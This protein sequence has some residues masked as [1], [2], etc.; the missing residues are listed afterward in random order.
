MPQNV[1]SVK[2]KKQLLEFPQ[3][4]KTH[5]IIIIIIKKK[6]TL[7]KLVTSD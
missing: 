6:I 4:C 2:S 7:V 1:Y 3:L 5:I